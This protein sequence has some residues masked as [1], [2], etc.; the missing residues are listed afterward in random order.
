M[1][2]LEA[3]VMLEAGWDKLVD[4]VWAIEVEPRLSIERMMVRNGF[5]LDE[6][7]KRMAMQKTNEERRSKASVVI[8]NEGGDEELRR[9]LEG[10]MRERGFL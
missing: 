3:A 7:E 1:V 2:V 4:E 10:L 6:C 8:R 5:T 9:Q